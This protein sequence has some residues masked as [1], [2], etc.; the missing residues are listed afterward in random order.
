MRRLVF[1]AILAL[2]VAAGPSYGWKFASIADSRTG[3]NGVNVTELTTIVNRINTENVDLV[4]FEGDACDGSSDDEVLSSQ[5]DTWLGVMNNLNCPWWYSPGNHEIRSSTSQDVLRT[6]VDQPLNGPAGDL[7][8]VYS[9]DHENAHFVSLN[10]NH[11]GEDHHVQRSWLAADLAATSQPHKFVLAHEPAYPAGPHVGSSLDAY[12]SERDDFWSIMENAGVRMYFTGHEHLY[13]RSLHGNIYQVIN[14]TCGA[15]ISSGWPDTVAEYHYVIVEIDGLQVNC[16]AKYD[17]GVT[18]DTWSYD[19]GGVSPVSSFTATPDDGRVTLEWT[20]P[21]SPTFH[22]T[23]IRYSTTA[24]PATPTDGTLLCDRAAAPSSTDSFEHSGLDNWTPYYYTAFAHDDDS[25]YADGVNAFGLP[26]TFTCL[27]AKMLPDGTPF[28]LNDVV[29]TAIFSAD[30]AIY[31]EEPDRTSGIRVVYAGSGLALGDRVNVSGNVTSRYENGQVAEREITTAS[32]AKISSG[33]PLEPV[34]MNCSAIGGAPIPPLV[35]GVADGIGVNNMGL[36]VRMAGKVTDNSDPWFLVD[37]GSEI[38]DEYGFVGVLIQCPASP[39]I[40]LDDIVIVTGIVE[41][42]IPY[43][44]TSN[45]RYI[46]LRDMSDIEKVG[47]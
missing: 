33:D 24:Y 25:T 36:L 13:Q 12:P 20:N 8:M 26:G 5:M 3:T 2:A 43:D 34:A 28:D 16:E 7:E 42:S 38:Q 32:V 18:F 31:V 22:A 46:H 11:E 10:S 21:P 39:G 29:V 19:L 14:G 35:P 15:P 9:F 45:R 17:N 41:G 6:K 4:I 47:P 44:W 30:G 23:V 27:Y 37:D 40:A 1:A